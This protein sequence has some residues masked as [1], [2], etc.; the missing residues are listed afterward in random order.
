MAEIDAIFVHHGCA[1]MPRGW[2]EISKS[3][4]FI[5]MAGLNGL[6]WLSMRLRVKAGE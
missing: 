1:T 2:L 6:N 5:V 4:Y 3:S